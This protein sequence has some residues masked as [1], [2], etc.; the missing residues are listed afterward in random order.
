MLIITLLIVLPNLYK[1]LK[2]L[3][4]AI[5]C[6]SA[7]NPL[8]VFFFFN[9]KK[10]TTI[11]LNTLAKIRWTSPSPAVSLRA[12]NYNNKNIFLKYIRYYIRTPHLYISKIKNPQYYT[13]I[14]LKLPKE[15]AK[16]SHLETYSDND[17]KYSYEYK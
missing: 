7:R 1:Y 8:I 6:T 2:I 14:Y 16:I 12:K 15:K 17:S 3:Y 11:Q 13:S 5:P 10:I 9:K 4:H